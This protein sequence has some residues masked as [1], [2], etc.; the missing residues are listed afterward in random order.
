MHWIKIRATFPFLLLS[1]FLALPV[2]TFAYLGKAFRKHGNLPPIHVNQ[3]WK[4]PT[5]C[6]PVLYMATSSS[7]LKKGDRKNKKRD[8]RT[9][10]TRLSKAA[11]EAAAAKLKAA[12]ET[13]V[14]K[15]AKFPPRVSPRN[16]VVEQPLRSI[17]DL[18]KTI[19][20]ELL[21]PRDGYRPPRETT[22]MRTLLEHNDQA[23]N[24]IAAPGNAGRKS[25]C[26]DVAMVFS[27][28]LY[29]DQIT[30]EYASRLVLLAQIIKDDN[31]S[32]SLIC[33]CGS[34]KPKL[35]NLVSETSAGVMF[36][37][38]LCAANDI[39]LENMD[40]CIINHED[41]RDTSWSSSTSLHPVA[42]ELYH[43]GYLQSWLEQ[44]KIYE[45]A[46]DEYGLTRDEP[47]KK[48]HIHFTLIS[49]DYHLCNL[50]DIH[51]RSPRQSPLKAML[52]ELEHS[53]RSFRGLAEITW[54]FRY[55][56]YPYLDSKDDLTIF[57]GKCY[58][59]AQ[60][61]RPLL[62]NIRGVANQ[63]R[64][65]FLGSLLNNKSIVMSYPVPHMTGVPNTCGVLLG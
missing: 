40:I 12:E 52:Q 57:L 55:S 47:R 51:L 30:T 65:H 4:G 7:D 62:V 17:T 48:I 16:T 58:K 28:P 50:N 38:H 6:D 46:T 54:Q 41:A 11:K 37:R 32:P 23:S 24:A 19:D 53:I 33:F 13:T 26:K 56:P 60:E 20:E 31:Y 35:D 3:L 64:I 14:P 63:V 25:A 34:T 8:V 44:S 45:S 61:L 27:K 29:Q 1:F 10:A 22:S 59:L 42:E 9:V 39:S 15:F 36:F 43:R 18:S 49:T 5:G 21:R 2:T